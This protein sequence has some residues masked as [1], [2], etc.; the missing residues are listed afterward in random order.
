MNAKRLTLFALLALAAAPAFAGAGVRLPVQTYVEARGLKAADIR[1]ALALAPDDADIDAWAAGVLGSIK[2]GFV[3]LERDS[4]GNDGSSSASLRVVYEAATKHI[5]TLEAC[6]AIGGC[7]PVPYTVKN[8]KIALTLDGQAWTLEV[9]PGACA[10]ESTCDATFPSW[11]LNKRRRTD[12]GVMRPFPKLPVLVQLASTIVI[13]NAESADRW[14][15]IDLG[16]ID[17]DLGVLR[18]AALDAQGRMSLALDNGWLVADFLHDSLLMAT[19]SGLKAASTGLGGLPDA[20]TIALSQVKA[21]GV[22]GFGRALSLSGGVAVWEYGF[23]KIPSDQSNLAK[24][25]AAFTPFAGVAIA[26]EP[27]GPRVALKLP[28]GAL[29]LHGW[30]SLSQAFARIDGLGHAPTA[31]LPPVTKL[32]LA[33]DHLFSVDPAGA[34]ILNDHVI[35][36]LALTTT[37]AILALGGTGHAYVREGKADAKDCKIVHLA[38]SA[39]DGAVFKA[40]SLGA[41]C[42]DDVFVNTLGRDATIVMRDGYDLYVQVL[43]K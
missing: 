14:L 26:A 33:G 23:A 39:D 1:S 4:A 31:G 6:K 9:M 24:A 25:T 8:G 40:S 34:G 35:A 21:E 20:S 18:N 15:T 43:R 38:Q 7:D 30:V 13:F 22:N 19:S 5:K 10:G 16:G 32:A 29:E 3:A 12:G 28:S 41:E 17:E 2:P 36:P 42:G 37:G 11:A 27:Q